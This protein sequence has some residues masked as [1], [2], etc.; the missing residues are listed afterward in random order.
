MW[1]TFIRSSDMGYCYLLYDFILFPEY[2]EKNYSFAIIDR[3]T[4]EIVMAIPL[5]LNEKN[6]LLSRYGFALKNHLGKHY[7]IKL[8]SF[9]EEYINSLR[10]R[11]GVQDYQIEFCSL[12]AFNRS[13]NAGATINPAIFFGFEP[14]IR[15]TWLVDLKKGPEQIFKDFEQTTKQAVRTFLN[16]DRYVF[17]DHSQRPLPQELF[18][19]LCDDTYKRSGGEPKSKEY[20]M[21][22]FQNLSH[23][24]RNIYYIY[25]SL[26]KDVVVFAVV[27][28]YNKTAHY[29]IGASK[30]EK[31]SGISKFLFYKILLSLESEGYECIEMGGAYPYLDRGNKMRGI[32]DFKKCFGAFIHPIHLGSFTDSAKDC[33]DCGERRE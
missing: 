13:A 16:S 26:E 9:F 28:F 22:I 4:N 2:H 12:S 30:K 1:D 24:D 8:S 15:Y 31:P 25:D 20:L 18:L 6:Q 11:L 19:S 29:S 21:H 17:F 23:K 14:D 10:N 33:G 27:T 7:R 5:F 3:H 32:S